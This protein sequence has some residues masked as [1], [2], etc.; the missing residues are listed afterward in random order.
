MNRNNLLT[1]GNEFRLPNG[2]LYTGYYHIHV[3]KGPMVGAQHVDSEH[4]LLT[5]VNSTVADRVRSIQTELTSER[6]RQRNLTINSNNQA[7]PAPVVSSPSPSGGGGG[8]G[9]GGY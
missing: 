7:A 8:G 6:R 3:S 5:P 2:N 4:D 1:E 9:G